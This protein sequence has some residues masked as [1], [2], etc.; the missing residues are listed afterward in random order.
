MKPKIAFITP[1][2][3]LGGAERWILTLTKYFKNVDVKKIINLSGRSD[4]NLLTEAC[5][6]TDVV[7]KNFNN[8]Q[9]EL[10]NELKD[11]DVVISWAYTL[12]FDI[13][14]NKKYI[15]I[16]VAHSDPSWEN[17]KN[18]TLLTEEK[19]KYHVGVSKTAASS[20]SEKIKPK[21]I[22]NGIDTQRIKPT[23]KRSDQR[24]IWDVENKKVVFFSGRLS[25]EKNPLALVSSIN[26]FDD[27]WI[28]IFISNGIMLDYFK[29][30]NNK[31][32]KLVDKT[33]N[34]GNYFVA[35]DVFVMTSNVEGMPLSLLEAWYS[36]I[37]TV[38]TE[39]NSYKEL[40]FI[41]G[42]ISNSVPLNPDPYLLYQKINY[43]YEYR[44]TDE[45]IKKAKKI[46]NEYYTADI[47]AKN[48]EN[49][50]FEILKNDNKL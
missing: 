30:L 36:E 27:S 45:K 6:L 18:L 21:I 5:S 49:Y 48:W 47:M 32:I 13:K 10:E 37:P 1:A 41:H 4:K 33:L 34:I 15:S 20:F 19:S 26:Y 28:F 29:H 9:E 25:Q 38:T 42:D 44:N 50:I 14:N 2:L 43:A 12:D 35:S 24:K 39:Y 23:I 3:G 46:L 17:Q 22:Y 11:I 7:I 31:K 40:K 16:D 8:N